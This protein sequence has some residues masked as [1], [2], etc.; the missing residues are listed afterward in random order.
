M[1]RREDRA[2]RSIIW[3]LGGTL[4]D[5][6]PD[7]DRALALAAFGDASEQRLAEVGA[8]TR[9]S[10]GHAIEVLARRAGVSEAALQAAY[11]GVKAYWQHTPAPVQPGAREVMAAVTA[12]GGLNLVATHRDRASAEQLI[13]ATGLVIDDMVCAPDGFARKPAPEMVSVLIERHGL[14][15]AEVIVVGD[16]PADAE[17]G[18]AVGTAGVLLVTPG[19]PLDAGDLPQIDRLRDLV[20]L[21]AGS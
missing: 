18:L 6:Y 14:D 16:R 4:V 15:P 17:A 10:S 11:D 7:V 3:D 19:I 20:P 1:S 8:L 21:L 2:I 12:S 13:A 9:L 5:T